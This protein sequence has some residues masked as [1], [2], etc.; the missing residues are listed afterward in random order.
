MSDDRRPILVDAWRQVATAQDAADKR[1]AFQAVVLMVGAAI[2]DGQLERPKAFDDLLD[3]G[4]AHNLFRT[5]EDLEHVISQGFEGIR[6]LPIRPINGA[7][8]HS[9]PIEQR[10]AID[11]ASQVQPAILITPLAWP[12]E[13]PP[14]IEWVADQRIPRGDVTTLHGDGGAGK[15]DI[16][17]TLAANVA[18]QSGYW[19][20]LE[21]AAGPVVFISAEEPERDIRRRIARH[22]ERDGYSLDQLADLHL[23]FPDD[24]TG[25]TLAIGD[26]HGFMRPTPLF[27]SLRIAIANI[28]PALVG[29]DNVAATYA[30]NQNDRVGAR[31]FVN[32][33]RAVARGPGNPAVLLLDHPSLSGIISGTGRGGNMDWRNAVRSA[34]HLRTPDDRA[35]ADRGI[36]LLRTEKSNYAKSGKETDIRLE[37]RDGGL[38]PEA[39]PSSL[40]RLAIDAECEETFLRLLDV[41]LGQGRDVTDK[42][43]PT[44]APAVFEAMPENGGFRRKPFAAAM[45]RLLLAGR[46][47]VEQFGPPSK[48]RS[49]LTRKLPFAEAAE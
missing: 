13:P 39:A 19:L 38:M 49:R 29:V 16:A 47:M 35:E 28:A 18:R 1:E 30:G 14:P 41:R 27:E 3:L 48:Q 26:R 9:A 43:G 33:W 22:A 10:D 45:E 24:V 32:L 42:K 25:C 21:I 12:D 5:R 2:D 40:H 7:N 31:S 4:E 37:W 15:T 44:Y 17:T 8:R 20:G 11:A 36:R 34:L 46:V 23:W 6:A